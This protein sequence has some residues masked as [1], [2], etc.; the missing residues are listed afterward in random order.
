MLLISNSPSSIRAFA[1]SLTRGSAQARKIDDERAETSRKGRVRRD[2]QRHAHHP[3]EGGDRFS[4]GAVIGAQDDVQQKD[5]LDGGV[6]IDARTP[7]LSRRHGMPMLQDF[8][9]DPEGKVSPFG[10]SFVILGMVE[11][12]VRALRFVVHTKNLEHGR[13]LSFRFS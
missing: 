4:D 9:V 13:A 7:G 6:A 2:R 1:S 12:T 11:D 10:Q 8:L 5:R 3:Q